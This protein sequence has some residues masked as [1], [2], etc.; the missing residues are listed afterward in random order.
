[1]E[2]AFG[3]GVALADGQAGRRCVNTS[4]GHFDSGIRPARYYVI[5]CKIAQ[6]QYMRYMQCMAL[7]NDKVFQMRASEDFLRRIDD[8]RRRQPALPSRAEAIR[9]LIEFGLAADSAP[10]QDAP[11]GDIVG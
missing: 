3:M 1:L 11:S 6:R 8:W 7:V 5:T 4:L 10:Q 9:R 2:V